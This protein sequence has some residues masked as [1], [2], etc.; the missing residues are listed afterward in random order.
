L[1]PQEVNEKTKNKEQV[2]IADQIKL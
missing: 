1:S 2:N